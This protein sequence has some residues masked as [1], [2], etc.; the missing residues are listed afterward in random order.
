MPRGSSPARRRL[1]Q[2]LERLGHAWL[3]SG[4]GLGLG[5]GLGF[6]F[7]FGFGFG[8]RVKG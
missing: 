1:G 2:W 8:L 6:G 3:G 5:L 4:V 7:G